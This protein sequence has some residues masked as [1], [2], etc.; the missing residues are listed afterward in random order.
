MMKLSQLAGWSDMGLANVAAQYIADRKQEIKIETWG[1]LAP[2]KNTKYPIQLIAVV[3]YFNEDVLNPVV[4]RV[5][6]DG[7]W[8]SPWF[9]ESVREFLSE[10]IGKEANEGKLF[11]FEGH[12]RNYR[13]I[14]KFREIACGK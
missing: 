6:N 12:W 4:L 13:F 8:Y 5:E 9:Y 1:H 14:G 2:H 11:R 7:P 3:G 10:R